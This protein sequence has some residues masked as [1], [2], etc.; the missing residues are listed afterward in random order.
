MARRDRRIRAGRRRAASAAANAPRRRTCR[1]SPAP[2][3]L[4]S[5][6][7][8]PTRPA[9]EVARDIETRRR[10]ASSQLR[11]RI[12]AQQADRLEGVGL[13]S[14]PIRRRRDPGQHLELGGRLVR[15]RPRMPPP[16]SNAAGGAR[17][18]QPQGAG[19]RRDPVAVGQDV[20]ATPIS[21]S[22]SPNCQAL[23]ARRRFGS[24]GS[25]AGRGHGAGVLV[26]APPRVPAQRP[27][28]GVV[29]THSSRCRRRSCR[30]A[31]RSGPAAAASRHVR[32]STPVR[33]AR[34][35]DRLVGHLA[36]GEALPDGR[37]ARPGRPAPGCS[38]ATW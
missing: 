10:S 11:L 24:A 33:G 14:E 5:A 38:P 37:A 2:S 31:R 21:A 6:P 7:A 25:C 26:A 1:R 19:A 32:A 9:S 4:P 12:G 18:R 36:A 23:I 16:P 15:R 29:T 22:A 8:A 28:R 27:L 13:P 30:S 3:G 20:V 34:H 35:L 17:R